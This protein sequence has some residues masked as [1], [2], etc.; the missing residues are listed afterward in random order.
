MN[1]PLTRGSGYFNDIETARTGIFEPGALAEP[2]E[3]PNYS[4]GA[5]SHRFR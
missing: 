4:G 3:D 1:V 5:D 2:T